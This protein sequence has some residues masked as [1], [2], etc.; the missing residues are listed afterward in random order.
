MLQPITGDS[1]NITNILPNMAVATDPALAHQQLR[2]L[3]P[4]LPGLSAAA[5]SRMYRNPH[6]SRWQSFDSN[7]TD[8]LFHKPSSHPRRKPHRSRHRRPVLGLISDTDDGR[9]LAADPGVVLPGHR[10]QKP[11]L[12]REEAYYVTD[13][14]ELY[15]LGLL[16]DS[17]VFGLEAIVRAEP[18]YAVRPAKRARRRSRMSGREEEDWALRWAL[19]MSRSEMGESAQGEKGSP[20]SGLAVIHELPEGSGAMRSV[21]PDGAISSDMLPE[22]DELGWDLWDKAEMDISCSTDDEVYAGTDADD[23]SGATGDPWIM[24]GDDS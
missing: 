4:N 7:I 20:G 5:A 15:R 11:P 3:I 18:A 2:H 16:Y 1:S 9:A 21:G 13:D 24:L 6:D 10:F 14:A 8:Q 22:E 17:D 23:G 19:E 12:G